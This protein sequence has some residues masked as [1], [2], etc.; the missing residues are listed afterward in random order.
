MR[1]RQRERGEAHPLYELLDLGDD[2]L[3]DDDSMED[4]F[5]LDLPEREVMGLLDPVVGCTC[6]QLENRQKHTVD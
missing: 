1:E 5:S 4:M 3:D 2:L 6:R